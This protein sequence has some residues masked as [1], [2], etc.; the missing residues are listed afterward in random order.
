[1]FW[2]IQAYVTWEDIKYFINIPVCL[3]EGEK[4]VEGMLV[5]MYAG[6]VGK[7]IFIWEIGIGIKDKV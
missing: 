6:F 4:T 5:I 3:V 7:D 2:C 1:M